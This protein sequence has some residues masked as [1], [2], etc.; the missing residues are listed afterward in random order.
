MRKK[1]S[2]AEARKNRSQLI[3]ERPFSEAYEK[4]R[5]RFDLEELNL[6]PDEILRDVRDPSPGRNPR[7]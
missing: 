1:R 7:M 6:D 5:K 2:N 3:R 4:F